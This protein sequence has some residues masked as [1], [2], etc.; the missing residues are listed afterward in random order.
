MSKITLA[1]ALKLKNIITAEIAT[2]QSNVQNNKIKKADLE[3]WTKLKGDAYA[4]LKDLQKQVVQL[5]G[6]I[7]SANG[8]IYVKIFE[9]SEMKSRISTL[10]SLDTDDRDFVELERGMV[11]GNMVTTKTN[12]PQHCFVSASTV[13]EDTLAARNKLLKLQEEIEE[14]NHK[15]LIDA[16]FLGEEFQKI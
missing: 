2:L 15:T 12:V 1:K 6:A 3:Y 14:Y 9:I 4:R 13:S 10:A 7:A 11:A 8:P 16:D 5:K